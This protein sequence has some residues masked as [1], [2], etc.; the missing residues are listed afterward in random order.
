VVVEILVRNHLTTDATNDTATTDARVYL[1]EQIVNYLADPDNHD[2]TLPDGELAS[3]IEPTDAR[4]DNDIRSGMGLLWIREHLQEMRQ[5][6]SIVRVAYGI[7][8]SYE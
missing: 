4:A 5:V 7:D 8:V 1:L 6:T 2:L 3:Y